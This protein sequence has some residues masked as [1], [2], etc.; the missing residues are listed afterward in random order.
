M[1][2][3]GLHHAGIMTDAE[4]DDAAVIVE[5]SIDGTRTIAFDGLGRSAD[6]AAMDALVELLGPI[7]NPRY[8]LIRRGGLASNGKDYLAIPALFSPNRKAAGAFAKNWSTRI[9]PS[10]AVWTRSEEGRQA[11]LLARRASLSA[12]MQRKVDRRSEWR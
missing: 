10:R 9:G 4:L 1:I 8:L 2:L 6:I 12:G 7:Q 5:G 11:L 3:W